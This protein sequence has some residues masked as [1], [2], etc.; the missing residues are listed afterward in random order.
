[1]TIVIAD[2]IWDEYER[3]LDE[4]GDSAELELLLVPEGDVAAAE[5][6][7]RA[8]AAAVVDEYQQRALALNVMEPPFAGEWDTMETSQGLRVIVR[9][10]NALR[11]ALPE[12]A[13]R[14]SARGITGTLDLSQQ[15]PPTRWLP[16]TAPALMCRLR[17]QGGRA[18]NPIGQGLTWR[19]EPE[20]TARVLEIAERWSRAQRPLHETRLSI[21]TTGDIVLEP[22]EDV[23]ARLQRAAAADHPAKLTVIGPD[24]GFRILSVLWAGTVALT[25]GLTDDSNLN[26]RPLVNELLDVLRGLADHVV[27]GYLRRGWDITEATNPG[28]THVDWPRREA[29]YPPRGGSTRFAFEN[30]AAPDAFGVQL[31][32]PGYADRAITSPGWRHESV[33]PERSL[34]YHDDFDAWFSAPFSTQDK[35][36]T[37][38]E[39][40]RQTLT[41]ARHDLAPIL[42]SPALLT[43]HGWPV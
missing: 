41:R 8:V 39:A 43:Q 40:R 16:W 28:Y 13:A 38:P 42:A 2:R 1:L 5:D 29:A 32:G 37:T 11:E 27:Y 36:H 25:T 19:P 24:G 14:L 4:F 30:V 31:L 12:V 17:L 20:A 23:G 22:G 34:L 33:G 21:G 7:L 18:P 10:S 9:E 3:L 15:T 35:P 26:W 6:A